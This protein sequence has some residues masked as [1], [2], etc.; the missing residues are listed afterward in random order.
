MSMVGRDVNMSV[1]PSVVITLL[2]FTKLLVVPGQ[3]LKNPWCSYAWSYMYF[4]V[5]PLGKGW[6]L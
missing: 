3:F 5:M 1:H 6:Q 4:H 2:Q